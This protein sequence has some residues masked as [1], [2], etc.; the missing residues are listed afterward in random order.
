MEDM[1]ESLWH[2]HSTYIYYYSMLALAHTHL[3]MHAAQRLVEQP[4]HLIAL[5]EKQKNEL[6]D[7]NGKAHGAVNV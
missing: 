1:Q 6:A 3:H 4:I 7:V 2:F 5:A